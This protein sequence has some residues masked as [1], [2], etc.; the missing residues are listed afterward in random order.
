[1]PPRLRLEDPRQTQAEHG[2]LLCK[3]GMRQVH[4]SH[5]RRQR[6]S[7]DLPPMGTFIK[8]AV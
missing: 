8:G 2:M 3:V 7:L 5:T 1:M 4:V 6:F